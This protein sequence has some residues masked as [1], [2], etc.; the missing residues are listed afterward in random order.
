M[1]SSIYTIIIVMILFCFSCAT[2]LCLKAFLQARKSEADK[3]EDI[4]PETN[5]AI[6]N[7]LV[8]YLL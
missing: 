1:I 8:D 4:M 7:T 2:P 5:W 6:K 3:P